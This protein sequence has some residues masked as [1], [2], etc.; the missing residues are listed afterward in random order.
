VIAGACSSTSN[1]PGDA[2]FF[3]GS[4]GSAGVPAGDSGGLGGTGGTGG[5]GGLGASDDD[6]G[7]PDAGMDAAL[8]DAGPGELAVWPNAESHT[9]SDA[10][11]RA[12]HASL[13]RLEPRVLVLDVQRV[14]D[15]IEE[16]VSE[17]VTAVA[18][19][20]RYHGYANAQAPAFLQYQIDK[21]VDLRDPTAEYPS[22]WPPEPFDLGEL[23]TTEFAPRYGYKDPVD[24]HDLTLCE[25][26]E[27]GLV[28]EL[29]IAA[30]AG[31]RNVYENQSYVQRYDDAL[32]PIP[33]DFSKC[34]NGCF[35]DPLD[36]VDCKVS[37]RVQEVNKGRG[38][39]CFT[40]AQGH[41]WENELARVPYLRE[42][43]SRFFYFGMEQ[44][45]GLGYDRLYDMACAGNQDST[46]FASN[47]CLS[48]PQPTHLVFDP[49]DAQDPSLDFDGFGQGCGDVHHP[50]NIAWSDSLVA[51][52]ACEGY[53]L[54]QGES[55]A[56]AT[57]D[58]TLQRA[59]DLFGGMDDDCGGHWQLYMRQSMPGLGN[60]AHAEDG[61]P[62]LNWWTFWY[63]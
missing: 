3:A 22:Y 19:G 25:I 28:N 48:F 47:G 62:M 42:N 9:N 60:Q 4:G 38:A 61:A 10:W 35:D 46:I 17:I 1:G 50:A 52:T 49:K 43:A 59:H 24:A 26:F 63:Y 32:Q 11:L 31:V 51:A 15:P 16:V 20:S 39:G 27:R 54:G 5:T 55:G 14:G 33:G 45:Y 2:G 12:H 41:A 6:S 58:F 8:P 30:E 40:H 37:V 23:F 29:W 21:I 36:R 18:E 44:R 13:Q 7:A 57:T 53:G 56:D 34:T